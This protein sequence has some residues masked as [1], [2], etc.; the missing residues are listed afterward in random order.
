M[1]WLA[2]VV[3]PR[4]EVLNLLKGDCKIDFFCGYSSASGQGGAKLDGDL[5]ERLGKMRLDLTI[6]LY[7]PG[8][9]TDEGFESRPDST[10]F[11]GQS[12]V[13]K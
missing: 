10:N 13:L 9:I 11:L 4:I 6:D 7:P 2:A 1:K 12:G 8:P 5:L 3:E